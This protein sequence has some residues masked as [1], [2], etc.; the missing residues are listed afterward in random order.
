MYIYMYIYIFIHIYIHT[1]I[2][3][4]IYIG[5]HLPEVMTPSVATVVSVVV[6]W[7][8]LMTS[9]VTFTQYCALVLTMVALQAHNDKISL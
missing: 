5:N 7:G 8:V 1:Y 6:F 9:D 2:Y 4:Y 3:I